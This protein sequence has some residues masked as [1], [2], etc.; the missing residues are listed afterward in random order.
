MLPEAPRERIEEGIHAGIERLTEHLGGVARRRVVV[1]L[2]CVLALDT[3]DKGA[4]GALAA[5]LEPA[6]HIGNTQVGLLVAVSTLIG[7]VMTLPIGVLTDR[8]KRTRL[9]WISIIAWGIAQAASG[10]AVSF[11]MLLLTRVAVGAVTA[12]AGPVVASL[13]GDLFPAGERGRLY[14]FILTGELIGAGA[15]ILVAG[16]VTA[17]LSWRAAFFAL[18]VPSL[19]LSWAVHHLLPEPAR[20][21][22]SRLEPGAEVI[23][24]EEVAA[25]PEDYEPEA[26]E[27]SGGDALVLRE[28]EAA[29]IEADEEVV[30]HE[31]P[32]RL[33]LWRAVLYVLRVRTNLAL[34]ISSSLGY[35]FFAGVQ[36]FALIF[37]RGRYGLSQSTG[38]LLLLLMGVGAVA[39]VLVGGRTADR[40]LRRGRIDARLV[41]GA[42]GYM[43]ASLVFLPALWSGV[44]ALS[45]PP[46]MLAAAA[47][48]APNP[49]LIAARLDVIPSRM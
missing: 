26:C 44:V 10:L 30:L 48:A 19:V 3:A 14:G 20:G 22:Q 5:Q 43:V 49:P 12:T 16:E 8:S 45:L 27:E 38:T 39:G 18:A 41:V 2:A 11:G 23:P 1:I 35:F 21:G 15:G 32:D 40:L 24:S 29:G 36:T 7:A 25:H 31:D 6:L 33:N 42:V 13:T 4:I 28:V 46:F 34:I 37:L 17:L 47:L 9:L